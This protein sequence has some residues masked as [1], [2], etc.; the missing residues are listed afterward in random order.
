MKRTTRTT[1]EQELRHLYQLNG[2]A[3]VV[4]ASRYDLGE[5]YAVEVALKMAPGGHRFIHGPLRCPVTGQPLLFAGRDRALAWYA[6]AL[7]DL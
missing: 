4:E 3:Q 7:G 2:H 1:C 6:D 5:G